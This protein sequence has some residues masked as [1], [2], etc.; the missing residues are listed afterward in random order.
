MVVK[1]DG[2]LWAMGNNGSGQL[3]NGTTVDSLVPIKVMDDVAFVSAGEYHTMAI[4]TNGEL[5]GWGSNASG[6]LGDG[7]TVGRK[8]PVK[9]MDDVLAVSAGHGYTMAIK[10]NGSLWAWGYNAAGKL[11]DRTSE[12]RHF[13]IF[14]MDDVASVSAGTD[15]TMAIKTDGSLWGWGSADD[16]RLGDGADWYTH[17]MEHVK[18]MDNAASVSAGHIHTLAV[19]K[20][21]SIWAWGANFFGELGVGPT[22]RILPP[23]RVTDGVMFTLPPVTVILDGQRVSFDVPPQTIDGRVMLPFRAIS[24]SLGVTVDWN[25]S[26]QTITAKKD[27]IVVKLP[28]GSVS[29]T[30]NGQIVTVDVPALVVE[31][32][33]LVPLRFFAEAF[34]VTVNWDAATRTVAITHII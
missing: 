27:D 9:V 30:V 33:T 25:Q 12:Y 2:S 3:G 11:G 24:E 17:K 23:V 28:I 26:E 10:T 22:E 13:P 5:W 20:D 7:T 34:G 1:T 4:K 21:G 15:H 29:P 18:I 14:I 31:G 32:R 16:G 8:L 19:K 6:A